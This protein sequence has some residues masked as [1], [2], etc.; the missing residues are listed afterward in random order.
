M[1]F[2]RPTSEA[3]SQRLNTE[4]LK[5][6]AHTSG[7]YERRVERLKRFLT[8]GPRR[9]R[10]WEAKLTADMNQRGKFNQSERSA[11]WALTYLRTYKTESYQSATI[12]TSNADDAPH[13]GW[14]VYYLQTG[15]WRYVNPSHL[16]TNGT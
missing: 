2:N 10:A 11:A 12:P 5:V 14:N 7:S 13:P 1:P 16:R 6:G 8:Y 4:L 3:S 9:T 15:S